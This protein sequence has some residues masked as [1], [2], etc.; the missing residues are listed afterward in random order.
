VQ[1][2]ESI[3]AWLAQTLNQDLSVTPLAGDASFRRYYRVF[4]PEKTY[5]L[6]D[7]PPEK[8]AIAPFINVAALLT[9]QNIH[10]PQ[11]I[12]MNQSEGF[13]LLSDFGDRLLLNELNAQ[14]ADLYYQQALKTLMTLQQTPAQTLPIFDYAFMLKEMHLC[15]EWFF[16]AYLGLKLSESEL[17]LINETMQ[18]IAKT[19]AHQPLVFI[20]RDYHSRN[21]MLL[22]AHKALGVLDFQ[23]AMLGPFVYDLVSLLKDCY[24]AWPR[25][26]VVQ[27]ALY[28]KN[29]MNHASYEEDEFI[30]VFDLCGLQRHLKVLGVFCR[31]Y[32]RDKKAAYLRDLPLTL[33]YVLECTEI[34]PCF[35][36]FFD[37]MQRRVQLP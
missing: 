11:I 34:Y 3:K 8:E 29:E 6:M 20:H 16:T 36:P 23:D 4:I 33:R 22:E 35:H 28:F 9:K 21:L 24:I 14:T 10:T 26:Q 19:L 37:F 12:A 30:R 27:W 18:A 5:V 7:A 1:R 2:D 15:I 32:L 31:L 25:E 17:L 13:L